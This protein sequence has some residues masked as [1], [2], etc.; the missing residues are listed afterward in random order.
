MHIEGRDEPAHSYWTGGPV[1]HPLHIVENHKNFLQYRFPQGEWITI[2]VVRWGWT[3]DV[4]KD[5]ETI[6]TSG[7]IQGEMGHESNETPITSPH[8]Q[9]IPETSIPPIN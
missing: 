1:S 3:A 5:G 8:I 2:G 4:Y 9:D 6:T 7:T